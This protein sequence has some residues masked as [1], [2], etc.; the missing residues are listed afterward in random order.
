MNTPI[1]KRIFQPQDI[2]IYINDCARKSL[3]KY[4]PEFY[5]K[6]L[7][8]EPTN[9]L[10]YSNEKVAYHCFT[11]EKKQICTRNDAQDKERIENELKN[12]I[13][14]NIEE[15]FINLKEKNKKY[16]IN[17]GETSLSLEVLPEKIL[18][19][20]NKE[21]TLSLDEEKK[22]YSNFIVSVSSPLWDFIK[23]SNEILNEEFKCNCP[24][25]SCRA[26]TTKLMKENNNYAI[27]LFVG[28]RDEVV[29]TIKDYYNTT[30]R[31][32]VKNC[33]KTP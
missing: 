23:I 24:R 28:S 1:K 25:E 20:I 29:Y 7:Y 6:G 5:L 30:F 8:F 22:P 21:V 4:L 31:F 9:Y 15:C 16:D 27:T 10:I 14:E 19:K 18:I 17:Y 2:E 33:D 26:D 11:N 13:Q 12:K 32:A 3:E